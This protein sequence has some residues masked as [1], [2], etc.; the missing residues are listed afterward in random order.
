VAKPILEVIALDA[1]DA[2]AAQSGGADRIELVSD[3]VSAGLTPDVET[4]A[5]VRAAVDLPVRVMLRNRSGYGL[6]DATGLSAEVEALRQAG[7]DQFVLGFLD[8]GGAVDVASVEA[9][10]DAIG[11]CPWTFHRAFDHTTDRTAGWRALAGLPGLDFVLTAGGPAG[12]ADGIATLAAEARAAPRI[13]AGGGLRPEHVAPLRAAGVDAFHTG[14]AVRPGGRWDQPVDAALVRGWRIRL[15]R[16]PER[17]PAGGL[18]AG[19][20]S[21][22]P[23]T[24]S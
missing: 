3:M 23:G 11:G 22:R 8:P 16:Q 1:A 14:A 20:R 19:S 15:D 10:L 6:S 24:D 13:L 12:V 9:V 5:A 21:G 18:R 17:R 7:A 2:R 4:F